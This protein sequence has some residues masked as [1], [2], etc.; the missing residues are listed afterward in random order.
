[1]L[2]FTRRRV[3]AYATCHAALTEWGGGGWPRLPRARYASEDVIQP[4]RND[5]VVELWGVV[6]QR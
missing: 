5:N 1:M 6:A 3:P 2:K 4:R